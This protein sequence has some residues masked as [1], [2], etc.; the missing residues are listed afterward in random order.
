M[1]AGFL[2]LFVL[3]CASCS[4]QIRVSCQWPSARGTRTTRFNG[5]SEKIRKNQ[6][7]RFDILSLFDSVHH[8]FSV[9][10]S[11]FSKSIII[12]ALFVRRTSFLRTIRRRRPSWITIINLL[13][14]SLPRPMLFLFSYLT[15]TQQ[16][17]HHNKNILHC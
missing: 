15:T 11:C 7:S 10:H 8:S 14:H 9:I 6:Q 12:M 13:F 5:G 3:I 17:L 4:Y 1:R 16:Q 2:F